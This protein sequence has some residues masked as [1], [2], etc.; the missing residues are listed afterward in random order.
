MADSILAEAVRRVQRALPEAR[1]LILTGSTARNEQTVVVESARRRWLSDCEFLVVLPNNAAFAQARAILDDVAR[2]CEEVLAGQGIEV[3]VDFGAVRENY[4]A[5][6]RPHIF[7]YELM[8]HGRML[9]GDRD[10]LARIPRFQPAEIPHADAWK[11]VSN[12]TVEWLE[13]QAAED[14]LT[15]ERQFYVLTKI[16]LDLITSLGVFAGRYEPT[17]RARAQAAG[18]I[19][20]WAVANGCGTDGHDLALAARTAV[21]F[22]FSPQDPEFLNW[23]AGSLRW[24]H[25]GA[26][27]ALAAVWRWELGRMSGVEVGTPDEA[28]IAL[29]RVTSTHQWVREWGKVTLRPYLRR[30]G[31]FFS[32]AWR[33][34]PLG[35][36]AAL[37]YTC[38][39][40][41]AESRGSEPATLD[42]VRRHL[43]LIYGDGGMRE[44]CTRNWRQYLRK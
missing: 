18:D 29:R 26:A 17:Y 7:G 44:Q 15:P 33:L 22:K 20:D 10:Y 28:L 37:V 12:R 19:S 32:R 35:T 1:A 9:F 38:A 16:W 31:R 5:S 2:G 4:F 39:A 21:R 14:H 41:L 3:E 42:W 6:L 43:P 8:T 13:F 27:P 30:S 25:E 11:L 40:A 23:R 34:A 24:M 36:P